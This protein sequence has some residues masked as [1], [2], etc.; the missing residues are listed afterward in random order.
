MTAA[1][2]VLAFA[3][4]QLDR[5]LLADGGTRN[6]WIFGAGASGAREVLSAIA[7]TMI[8]V[9]G[10]VFSITIVA[11]Q[12]ASSQFTPRVL[13]SFTGDR[14]NQIV[15]GVFIATFTYALLVLRTVREAR[16]GGPEAFVPAASVTV[17]IGLGIVSIGFLIYYIGHAA[18]SIR[19]SVIID[20]ATG[21]LLDL[22]DHLP[23]TVEGDTGNPGGSGTGAPTASIPAV[24]R[25]EGS[26]YL[27]VINEPTL[28]G[29]RAEEP[30]TVRI[31]PRVGTFV[32]P[33][34]V[35]ASVWPATAATPE[36][37]HG[38][39]R[40]LVLGPER[41][42][43][44]DLDLGVRQIAD[45][46]VRALSPGVN[47]P[48]TALI[49][50][51]RLAGAL[52]TLAQREE[53]RGDRLTRASPDGRVRIEMPIPHF[54]DLVATAFAQIRHFGA[55][56]AVVVAHLARTLGEMAQ[57]VP[58]S[59]R[60]PLAREARRLVEEAWGGIAVAADREAVEAAARWAADERG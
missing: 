43:R 35:V 48:T 36:L 31:A 57:A 7:G 3:T 20:R 38:V 56:D 53:S 30:I 37:H 10:V 27:Q 15:L 5:D 32:L 6:D 24:I 60:L 39:Q 11:L 18:T 8:T 23:A 46:A 50:I 25:S 16:D 29:L 59:E 21:D 58:P 2:A 9:A 33:G 52:V 1:A 54:A 49:C 40:A 28:L 14:G 41:S 47:D 45:I 19:A 13:R 55:G 17:A 22:I 44:G 4:V 26:G 34:A 42:V 12:L 51:D